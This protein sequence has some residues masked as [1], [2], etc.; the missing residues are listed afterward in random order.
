ML[1]L[2]LSFLAYQ[3]GHLLLFLDSFRNAFP[4][5]Q[6]IFSNTSQAKNDKSFFCGD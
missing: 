1:A 3:Y 6:H 2:G 5:K 4:E